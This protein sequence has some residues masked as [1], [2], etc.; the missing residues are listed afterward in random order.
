[1]IIFNQ[2]SYF[3]KMILIMKTQ[4]INKKI[5]LIQMILALY[6]KLMKNKQL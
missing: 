1:M 5:S 6:I 2:S 3:R 4:K